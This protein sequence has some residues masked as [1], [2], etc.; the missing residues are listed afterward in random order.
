ML[1]HA[2]LLASLVLALPAAAQDADGDI[3]QDSLLQRAKPMV[4]D[5]Y[6]H[7]D[8]IVPPTMLRAGLQ[9]ME[10]QS[11]QILVLKQGEDELVLQVNDAS[12]IVD[13]S[14][15]DLDDAFDTFETAALWIQP[16]LVDSDITEDD[17]RTA[18]L[19][20]ALRTI[21]RHSTVIAGDRLDDFNVRFKGTLVGIGAR[22]GRRDGALRVIKPFADAPAGKAGLLPWD[23]ISHVDGVAT[24]AMSVDD[25]VD[26][27]R[28]PEGVPVVLRVERA[29]E[30]FARAFVIV[31]EEVLV[32]SVESALLSDAIGYVNIDHFSKET[33]R[34]FVDHLDALRVQSRLQGLI[35][36]LR[37]NQGGS[38]IHAAR[39][40]NNFVESG[41]L[42]QTEGRNGGRVRGLTWKV[43][44]QP[45]NRRFDGP[46]VVLVD[47]KTASGSEI[48]AGGIKFLERGLIVGQQTFGKG[49]VQ[50][51]YSLTRDVS[52]KLTVA[53]YLLPGEK[54]INHVG[55]TPDVAV[56]Q[57]WLDPSD[58]TVPDGFVESAELLGL[59]DGDGGL[60]A[61]KN[62][63]AGRMPEYGGINARPALRLL[64]PR[65]LASWTTPADGAGEAP[66]DAPVAD[67]TEAAAPEDGEAPPSSAPE[68]PEEL[69][70]DAK[71]R[72]ALPGDAGDTQ[73]NDLE[74]RVAHELLRAALPTDRRTELLARATPIVARWQGT[75]DAR[76]AEGL[77]ARGIPWTASGSHRWLD[78]APAL[79]DETDAALSRPHP[80]LAVSLE[81]PEAL[82]AGE[83]ATATLVVRNSTGVAYPRL[84]ARIESS[85][86]ALDDASFVL[87]DL[88]PGA[89]R[90]SS[91]AISTSTRDESR[92]DSW[93]LYLLDDDGPLG[94][95]WEGTVE[96]RG[97][98][99]TPLLVRVS[100]E[101]EPEA[102][103]GMVLHTRV[104][105]RNE[106]GAPTGEVRILFG[107]PPDES[108]ERTER[109]RTLDPV[110]PGAEGSGTL[111]LRVRDPSARA[112]VPIPLRVTDLETGAYV[113]VHLELPTGSNLAPTEWFRP[114]TSRLVDAPPRGTAGSPLPLS[115]EVRSA[116]PLAS[117]EVLMGRD[118]VFTR[119]F[120]PGEETRELAFA[121]TPELAVGPNLI[122]VRTRTLDGVASSDGSWVLGER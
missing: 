116:S 44:A 109:F 52:M 101:L 96:T 122:T 94:G 23:V 33:S 65:I 85:A 30:D 11:P 82:L 79:E 15:A 3:D 76:L 121:I 91:I 77:A 75:Q 40:V 5:L 14:G 6:L 57:L 12:R 78:R 95:P 107:N 43:P 103:G 8:A 55:V 38:M 92:S 112:T 26:R 34:E 71:V 45:E 19:S 74:L 62:P 56:G 51:V 97:L 27:I 93:R 64:Y 39:I 73:F 41:T 90:R 42:V 50:K 111:S 60:D 117:V 72:S 25:A 80:D 29:G 58:P 32:P 16:L 17:L 20:G 100:T 2:L 10:H 102:A 98:P 113:T 53:R 106:G 108:V 105:V 120:A 114:A 115:G 86:G 119:R 13:V 36:D 35:I 84:R 54:F 81:L 28:G 68:D 9:A 37:G 18:A 89:E 24:E 1:R 67:A 87:G 69:V 59:E 104:E 46:V 99:L 118:K 66:A 21:D 22:I 83:R 88:P 61:R 4:R 7:P 110:G 48:V 63:G 31:R 70:G 49:T 47:E